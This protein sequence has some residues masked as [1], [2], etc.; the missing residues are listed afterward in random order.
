[1]LGPDPLT[2]RCPTCRAVQ[3]WSD[4]C[5]RCKCD[6]RLLR[7]LAGSYHRHRRSCLKALFA[8]RIDAARVHALRCDHLVPGAASRRLLAVSALLADDWA[9][10]LALARSAGATD[11]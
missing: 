4:T 10:A 7:Q 3:D 5:R 1:M 2:V 9:D 8:G 6:L 11:A